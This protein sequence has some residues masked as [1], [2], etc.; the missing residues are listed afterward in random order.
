MVPLALAT[1]SSVEKRARETKSVRELTA[2]VTG[3]GY[4]QYS[5]DN[6]KYIDNAGRY[7]YQNEEGDEY[8]RYPPDE[9]WL[10]YYE[11]DYFDPR[12]EPT[13]SHLMEF[14]KQR[15]TS[16]KRRVTIFSKQR[17]DQINIGDKIHLNYQR[18]SG[19]KVMIW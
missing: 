3:K 4:R 16:G 7:S 2:T 9:D 5:T 14:E 8:Q 15:I 11:I 10:I 19:A 6:Y 1:L 12:D 17:Y 18:F 13:S